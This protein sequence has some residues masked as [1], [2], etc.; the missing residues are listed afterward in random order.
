VKIGLGQYTPTIFKTYFPG[1]AT[2]RDD[3]VY[4]FA[5]LK[6]TKRIEQFI[7]NY[8]AEVFRWS[9]EDKSKDIDNFVCYDRI[10][11]SEHL[12]NELKREHYGKYDDSCVCISI[13]RPFC[14]KYLYYDALINDRPSSFGKTFIMMADEKTSSINIAICL[15]DLGS[16]K[17]FMLLATNVT[18]DR[19]LVGAGAAAQCFPYYI[20]DEDGSSQRENITDWALAQFRSK[21]GVEVNKWDIFHY[22][23]ALLHHPQYRERYRENLKRDLPRIPL[24]LNQETFDKCVSIGKQLMNL[25][26]HYEKAQEYSLAWQENK[27]VP[28]TWHVEKMRLSPDKSTL[29]VNEWLTLAD[30][31]QEC[32]QY[33]LGNRS[34]LEW[35]IDQ[36]QV[37]T[38]A[39][40]GIVSDPNREDDEQYIV[41]LVGKVVTVSVETVKLV[42][43]L[44]QKVKQED[45]LGEGQVE[46]S[47]P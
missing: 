20:Y 1:V 26:L 9:R 47:R 3:V 21:Y 2:G 28:I 43:E 22:V 41:R 8:N 37:S 5:F 17:P 24:L 18:S 33:R 13:Y 7:E 34:A 15:T 14:K 30:I 23:Y 40:S 42:E 19:H 44:A 45:W 10:K 27:D 32:Y 39:R 16:E 36:Y 6:L 46:V 29:K 12:K 11:W 35:I 4:D 25:H 38:D 31:P